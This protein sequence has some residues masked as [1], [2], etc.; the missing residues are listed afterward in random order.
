M[1][2]VVRLAGVVGESDVEGESE[3]GRDEGLG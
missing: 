2:V 3:I 1:V